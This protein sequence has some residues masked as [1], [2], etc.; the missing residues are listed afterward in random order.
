MLVVP[1][2]SFTQNFTAGIL[3]GMVIEDNQMKFGSS[4][5][6][7]DWMKG[8]NENNKNGHCDYFV[9]DLMKVGVVE[10]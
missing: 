9:T 7:H 3:K 6:A 10:L 1:V 2:Y 5:D 4:K 8:V